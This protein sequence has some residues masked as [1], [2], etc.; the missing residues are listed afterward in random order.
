MSVCLAH[1]MTEPL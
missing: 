1:D